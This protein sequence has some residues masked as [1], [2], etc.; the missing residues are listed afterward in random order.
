MKISN[1]V[2]YP[3]WSQHGLILVQK[4]LLIPN[5][6]KICLNS[7]WRRTAKSEENRRNL[8]QAMPGANEKY[9]PSLFLIFFCSRAANWTPVTGYEIHLGICTLR[10]VEG[11]VALYTLS[12]PHL[13]YNVF[14]S[15]CAGNSALFAPNSLTTTF[16][17]IVMQMKRS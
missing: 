4:F 9:L 1:E 2:V 7:Q 14:Q 11:A 5:K 17:N 3:A 6:N 13:H 15:G 8:L 12:F 10:A 16:N